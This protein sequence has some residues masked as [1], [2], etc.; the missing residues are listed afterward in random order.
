MGTHALIRMHR[1][2]WM[3]SLPKQIVPPFCAFYLAFQTAQT[4]QLPGMYDQLLVLPSPL[5]ARCREILE[6]IRSG[7]RL[8]SVDYKEVFHRLSIH[9][10][11]LRREIGGES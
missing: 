11:V 1:P 2:N 3:S 4:F 9:H 10:Q 8:P 6:L 7:G 5:G